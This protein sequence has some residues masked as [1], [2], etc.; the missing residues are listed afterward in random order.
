LFIIRIAQKTGMHSA[1]E[2]ESFFCVKN[3]GAYVVTTTQRVQVLLENN[4]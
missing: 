2:M 3:R 4:E 1:G